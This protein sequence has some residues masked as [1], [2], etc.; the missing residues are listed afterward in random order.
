MMHGHLNIEYGCGMIIHRVG[1]VIGG[2][3]LE[4]C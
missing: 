4:D 2:R 3:R 1:L